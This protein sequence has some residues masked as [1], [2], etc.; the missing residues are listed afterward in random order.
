[1]ASTPEDKVKA[2]V[3]ATLSR[4]GC[5]YAMPIGTQ[6]GRSGVPDFLVSYEGSF[7][8]LETKAG[9]NYWPSALQIENLR[10]IEAAGGKAMVVNEDNVDQIEDEFNLGSRQDYWAQVVARDDQR[11]AK[12]AELDSDSGIQI[13]K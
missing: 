3:K 6:Y 2:K 9:K 10:E 4:L 1:M 8:G 13:R 5:Y 12:M 11:R 7:I